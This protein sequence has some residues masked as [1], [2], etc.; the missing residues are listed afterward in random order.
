MTISQFILGL[1]VAVRAEKGGGEPAIKYHLLFL[2]ISIFQRYRSH[3]QF[4]WYVFSWDRGLWIL[5]IPSYLSYTV[6]SF[7][8]PSFKRHPLWSSPRLSSLLRRRLSC[9]PVQRTGG[10]DTQSTQD[11]STRRDVLLP[12][13]IHFTIRVR[14]VCSVRKC[15]D[16]VIILYHS[17]LY[18]SLMPL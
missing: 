12:G 8:C 5:H 1:Y 4:M 9:G 16:I 14:D 6:R 3:F 15:R 2:P 18:G 13:H 11:Y 17:P 7:S 10:P